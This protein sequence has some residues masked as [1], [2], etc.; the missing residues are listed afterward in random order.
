MCSKWTHSAIQSY[1]AVLFLQ[2][3]PFT[4]KEFCIDFF[5]VQIKC[6]I[7][8]I[9]WLMPV[10]FQN[11][12]VFEMTHWHIDAFVSLDHISHNA[13]QLVFS[14]ISSLIFLNLYI[15]S[16]KCNWRGKCS[17]PNIYNVPISTTA[18]NTCHGNCK[19]FGRFRFGY[20]TIHLAFGKIQ[21]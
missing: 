20:G 19:F 9:D 10:I 6:Y 14:F 21:N 7:Y 15:S 16:K 8:W 3:L 13:S 11:N 2:S 18:T 12:F 1:L 17:Y 4:D 5:C